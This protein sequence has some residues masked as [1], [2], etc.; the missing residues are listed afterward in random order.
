[1]RR[2]NSDMFDLTG[3]DAPTRCK[4]VALPPN[5]PQEAL[6]S[7]K[8]TLILMITGEYLRPLN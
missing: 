2:S 7:A 3:P 6:A 8:K 4:A 5:K 1:M